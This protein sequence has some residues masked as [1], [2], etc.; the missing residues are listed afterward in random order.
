MQDE[1]TSGRARQRLRTRKDLLQAASKLVREGRKPTL[2]EIADAAMVSRA[3][4]YRYYSSV[5]TI[6]AESWLDMRI[7]GPEEVFADDD[8]TDA[9]ERVW[10]ADQA[11]NAPTFENHLAARMTLATLLKQSAEK[12][13][14]GS[15]TPV[16]QNRRV[17]MLSAALAPVRSQFRRGELENLTGALALFI[18]IESMVVFKD[19]LR[20]DDDQAAR[21]RRWAMRALIE[22]AKKAESKR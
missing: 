8:S 10:R 14:E 19:V 11:I 9:F 13:G 22:A 16:R 21:V 3:T 17:A 6:L 4:A 20:L 7:P 18:G 12:A 5:E 2:E 15:D 1:P